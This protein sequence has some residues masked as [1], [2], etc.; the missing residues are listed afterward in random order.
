MSTQEIVFQK[1]VKSPVYN[2]SK[3]GLLEATLKACQGATKEVLAQ[4]IFKTFRS[5]GYLPAFSK[6]EDYKAGLLAV[7]K[8]RDSDGHYDVSMEDLNIA[9]K[10]N[11]VSSPESDPEK[12]LQSSPLFETYF[13]DSVSLSPSAQ[14]PKH[15]LASMSYK[16]GLA[17]IKMTYKKGPWNEAK[18]QRFEKDVQLFMD[19]HFVE[20]P[21]S[22]LQEA[23]DAVNDKL[24]K[25][26]DD[27]MAQMSK[28]GQ[29][30]VRIDCGVYAQVYS[31]IFKAAG[32]KVKF[33]N[34]VINMSAKDVSLG[35]HIIAI[36]IKGKNVI[37]GNNNKVSSI[38]KNDQNAVHDHITDTCNWMGNIYSINYGNSQK[39]AL[40]SANSEKMGVIRYFNSAN[41]SIMPNARK[42]A[43]FAFTP[44][45]QL[46]D[47]ASKKFVGV[48]GAETKKAVNNARKTMLGLVVNAMMD[49][50]ILENNADSTSSIFFM[51]VELK[52][53]AAI[54]EY[55]KHFDAVL[56][57]YKRGLESKTGGVSLTA[58]E[59]I[60]LKAAK[61]YFSKFNPSD[62]GVY[63]LYALAT[64]ALK[65]QG[66][67]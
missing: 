20:T 43:R 61:A 12:T 39:E 36:G 52:G 50:A 8:D 63:A 9:L 25:M 44:V 38:A 14:K 24:P 32:M 67:V 4:N 49:I 54:K 51:G 53:K 65:Q 64:Y 13:E 2:I 18:L 41:S 45:D 6:F 58:K 27:L 42:I 23:K 37:F 5:R 29:G 55:A 17:Y 33:A 57:I 47:G 21:V 16:E 26:S 59:V 56:S 35:N 10:A 48:S 60:E 1:P 28:D 3:N 30:R 34:L 7:I 40:N 31:D 62:G 46:V 22:T 66:A 11:F 19:A 15:P